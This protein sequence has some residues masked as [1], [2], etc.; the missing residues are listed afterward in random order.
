MKR[1]I[2]AG[3]TTVTCSYCKEKRARHTVVRSRLH[4]GRTCC[5][6]CWPTLPADKEDDGCMSEGDHQSWGRL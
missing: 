3:G 4:G 5:D 1:R 6:T 2:I